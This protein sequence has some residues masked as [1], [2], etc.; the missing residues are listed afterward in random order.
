MVSVLGL[1]ALGTLAVV[2]IAV[3]VAVIWAWRH[4]ADD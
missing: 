2:I 4:R 1:L 3:V